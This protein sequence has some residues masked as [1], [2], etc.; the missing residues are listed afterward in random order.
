[1]AA[2]LV[3]SQNFRD[4]AQWK[5]VKHDMAALVWLFFS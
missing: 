5:R 3:Q 1:M 4:A 2:E